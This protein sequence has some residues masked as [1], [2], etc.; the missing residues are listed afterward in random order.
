MGIF[1]IALLAAE[2]IFGVS[3]SAGDMPPAIQPLHMLFASLIFGVQFFILTIV[4]FSNQ[5]IKKM[6]VEGQRVSI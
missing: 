6:S 1:L 2:I 3:L 4:S 5:N